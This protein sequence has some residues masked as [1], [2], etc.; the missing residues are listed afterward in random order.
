PIAT[1]P[2]HHGWQEESLSQSSSE[3]QASAASEISL[4]E[5]IRQKTAASQEIES[6]YQLPAEVDA[7]CLTA[8]SGSRLGLACDRTDLTEFPTL[9]EGVLPSAETSRRQW[10][11][12]RA[13]G[14]LM[15]IQDSP[16]SPCLPLLMYSTQGQRLSDET[17]FQQSGRD[18]VPLRGVPDASGASEEH[19]EPLHIQEAVWLTDAEAPSDAPGDCFTVSQHP[20]PFTPAE[21]HEASVGGYLPQQTSCSLA[22]VQSNTEASEKCK[23]GPNEKALILQAGDCSANS[24]SKVMLIQENRT[25]K[26][27]A[28]L[29]EQTCNT[30]VKDERFTCNND[31]PALGFELA[32]KEKELLRHDEFSSSENSSCKTAL[33]KNSGKSE[34]E[35]QMQKVKMAKS[36][37]EG[38]LR[39]LEKAE[40]EKKVPELDFSNLLSDD[41]RKDSC[42]N[43]DAQDA[44]SAK[45]SEIVRESREHG[46]DLNGLGSMKAVAVTNELQGALLDHQQKQG[47]PA[48]RLEKEEFTPV[49]TGTSDCAP[50]QLAV[51]DMGAPSSCSENTLVEPEPGVR[52]ADFTISDFSIERGHKVTDISP[53][54]NIPTDDGSFFRH[55]SH[56]SYQSTPGI[57][58]NK[59]V[60]AE[61]GARVVKS[62]AQGSPLCLNE[63]NCGSSSTSTPTSVDKQHS[64]QCAQKENNKHFESL[65]LKYPHT[66]RIQS[67]PSLNFME[68]VGTWNMSQPGSVCDA[69]ASCVPSVSSPRKK[70]Y[71]ATDIS[72]DKILSIRSSSRNP[73]DSVTPSSGET[74]SLA[75]FHFH[76]KISEC[77]HPLTR[78]QSDNSDAAGKNA[79]P[80][81]AVEPVNSEA[82][83][84]LEAK[85][86]VLGVPESRLG[87][88]LIHRLTAELA[89]GSTDKDADGNSMGQSSDPNAFIPSDSVAQL[90]REDGNSPPDDLKKCD[91]LENERL[92]HNLDTP[93]GRV[94]MDNFGDISP[95]SLN[96]P[97]NSGE[98]SR[99]GLGSAGLSAVISG[100]FFTSAEGDNFI[101][102]GATSLKTPE[103]EEL[104]IEERIPIYLRNLGIDQSPGT[105]L[106][107]FVPRGPIREVEFSPS[108]LRTLKDSTDMLTRTAQQPRGELPAA[109]DI[110][111]TSF[112]SGTSTVSV[113]VPMNSEVGSGTL[114]PRELSPCFSR[115]FGDK[116]TSQCSMSCHQVE[117]TAPLSTQWETKCSGVS[118]VAEPSQHLQ[119]VSPGCRSN[120]QSPVLVVKNE[121]EDMRNNSQRWTASSGAGGKGEREAGKGSQT[122]SAGSERNKGQESD[123]QIRSGA[124]QEILKLLAEAEDIAGSWHDPVF[125]TASSRETGES[126]PGLPEKEDGPIDSEL[127]KD[128]VPQFQKIFSWDETMTQ[129]SRQE[130]RSVIK[131]LDSHKGSLKWEC[132][133]DVSL[134]SRK[135]MTEVTKEFRTEKSVG[136]SEP[137]GCSSVTTDRNQPGFVTVAQ[138]N[139]ESELST[140]R[141]SELGNPPPSEPLGS[142]TNVLEASWSGLLKASG[143]V[144]TA[145]GIRE[146]GSTSAD[147]LAARVKNLLGNPS[148]SPV[149]TT[150]VPGGFQSMLSKASAAGSQAGGMQ[151]SDGSS[152]GDSLA[153]R[154][155]NLLRNPSEP[156]GSIV[157]VPRGFPS[158]LK[159]NVAGSQAGGVQESDGSSSGDSLAARVKNLLRNGAPG[160]PTTQALRS[161]DEEERK[162]RA[163]VKLKLAS[164]SQES[165]SDLNEEDQQR[166]QEIKAELL[167]SARKSGRA[168]GPW[169]CSL[170]AALEHSCNQE[171]D[172]EHFRTPSDRRFHPDSPAQASR[173]K[174]LSEPSLQQA[175]PLGRAE[176][177]DS[178]LLKDTQ[179]KPLSTAEAPACTQP[180]AASHHAD[181]VVG[182]HPPLQKEWDAWA[183]RSA[184]ASGA[185]T[186][187]GPFPAQKKLSFPRCSEEMSKQ[188]TSITF[189]S[190]RRFQSPLISMV[191]DGDG[192]DEIVPLEVGSASTEEQSHGRQHWERSE[193]CPPS[194]PGLAG[195][196]SNE[197]AFPAASGRFRDVSA[198]SNRAGAYQEAAC[199]S[200]Q[201]AEERQT[202][203]AKS[204]DVLSQDVTEPGRHSARLLM[205]DSDTRVSQDSSG[206]HAPRSVNSYQQ[207][208][209][210]PPGHRCESSEGSSPAIQTDLSEGCGKLME[211]EKCPGAVLL[212]QKES[213]EQSGASHHS[214]PDEILSTT[215]G[216]PSSPIKKVLSCVH[217]TLSPKCSNLELPR[218]LSTEK[219]M[220]LGNK[221]EVN[222]QSMP[223]KTPETS[224][225]AVPKLPP[226]DLVLEDQRC[227]SLTVPVP[228]AGPCLVLS[229]VPSTAG[230]EL[231]SEGGE[232]PQAVGSGAC[233]LKNA[234]SCLVPAKT[235]STSDAA[236]QITTESPEKTT[237]SAEIYVSSQDG[238]SAAHQP[239][240]QETHEFPKRTTS[241]HNKIPSFPRQGGQ[242]VLLPYKPSGSTGMYYV[243]YLKPGSNI[244]PLGSE[245]SAESCHSGSNDAHP[246]RF[247]VSVLGLQDGKPPDRTA[248]RHK[249]G[250]CSKR[251]MPRLAWAEEQMLPLEAAPEHTHHLKTV[252]TTH[253]AFTSE[254]FSLHHPVSVRESCSSSSELSGGCAGVGHTG[255]SLGAAIR[256]RERAHRHGRVASA[257]PRRDGE[258][259]FFL[260][261]AE[262]DDSR[263]EDLNAG[264]PLGNETSGKELPQRGGRGAE[265][266]AAGSCPS[267][268]RVTGL[269][270]SVEKDLPLRRRTHPAGG[271]DELWGKFLERQ[272]RHQQHEWR[273]N[274]E[275]SLVERL[276]RLARVLQ[277]PIRYTLMPAKSES[278]VSGKKNKGKE[279]KKVRLPEKNMSESTLEPQERPCIDCDESSFVELRKSRLG[280][281]VTCHLN[282]AVEHRQYLE[283]SS[284]ASLERRLGKDL[285]TTISSTLSESDATQTDMEAT[286]QA[287]VSS[288][289]STIDTARLIRAFGH[290][291][292]RVSPRLS[293]LYC[294]IHQQKSRSEEWDKGSSRAGSVEYPKVPFE[295]HRKRK[296]T[297]KAV[298]VALDSTSTSS[299]SWGPSSAL[300]NKRRARMLNKGVQAGDLEIVNSATKKNTRDVGVTFPTP[301]SLQPIQR[302]REPWHCVG[303]ISGESDGMVTDHRA[304]GSK[305]ISWFVQAED[306]KSESRK[307]NCS[308]SCPGPGPSWFE[309]LTGTKP[310]REPLREKNCQEQQCSSVTQAA[311]PERDAESR[312]LRPLVKL[313]LQEAL[314]VHRP[315]FIS[316]SGER[317]K[318]LKL[319]MEERRMQSVLQSQREELFNPPEKR[320]GYRNASPMLSDRG[321]LIKEKR[322]TIRKSEMFQRSKRIYE[323]LPEVQRKREEEKRKTEYNSYRLKAQLY[324]MKI[325]NRVLG[326]KVP[327]N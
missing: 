192:L 196:C 279:Q 216:S 140:E 199:L 6:W 153:A 118:K 191:L 253:S 234:C 214:F 129:R 274:G 327:W 315:D 84:P 322:R 277:N 93:T 236:T 212:L 278:N 109:V 183:M 210:S 106:T 238:E 194:S 126:S 248:T 152:S 10:P 113:S 257:H 233:G 298:F 300:S 83:Q 256:S 179:L 24:T 4:G 271:L 201:D 137:E 159:A 175:V 67:L 147:S 107:P 98:S 55:F 75:G 259:E 117:V 314:A 182:L 181:G 40:K 187:K 226:A 164:S 225:E 161:A 227:S 254:R 157:D 168:K 29:A 96:L 91:D 23:N 270:D 297:Q 3:T 273:R 82:V 318:H 223:F 58:L 188:I 95:D 228:S 145:G 209:N 149:S 229:S 319:V 139:A 16:F 33:T 282:E 237:L 104:N 26:M 197:I 289:T 14:L 268:S 251:A 134:H 130:E 143:P 263:N 48:G 217:I 13:H 231:P 310:W 261:N 155:K 15:D 265:Q 280:E 108:D 285:C 286:A 32:E 198:G 176:P 114:S 160:T 163:W 166:I 135:E 307:E 255:P 9:E 246:L 68:K 154:V 74:R 37:S 186:E 171:R 144:S 71:S 12:N 303:G 313:T 299:S 112:D 110:T 116:P 65:K 232:R 41:V 89:S 7:S 132:S 45:T 86:N 184:A 312:P 213:A 288:S 281:K 81:E 92:P 52:K 57:F 28:S 230:Q 245:T 122:S 193:A 301:R 101:P 19:S 105:I 103:K 167:L 151:D 292:V 180:Q 128:S 239:S 247:P 115:S 264:T 284:D 267:C 21:L 66:G 203:S 124:V 200:D 17:L 252:K 2:P 219:D 326:R 169:S 224:L 321:Y 308:N 148:V 60:K 35:M 111:E 22:V 18:F 195:S 276:D 306:L 34:G 61:L 185:Q 305:G 250:I 69:L 207:E 243:P 11:G 174:E 249:E 287:E 189:S 99:G 323:Q 133:F 146:S 85:S 173:T 291:R 325:T 235:R 73:K 290:E 102:L 316:R 79:S 62:D 178:C 294:T 272:Q 123:S 205:A 138:S 47:S 56:P 121:L 94:S 39:H 317:V 38:C 127:V 211:E 125:S 54:F 220:R 76:S 283:T 158:M 20:L 170:G 244:F 177:S 190:R 202:L 51:A 293:Q 262:A 295:R 260:L 36:E 53:S 59:N 320:K 46:V 141:P 215:S 87:G 31:V 156:L 302:A 119:T 90:L 100:H 222:S 43:S 275:L 311:A 63:D 221:L 218:D 97:A 296:E 309:P 42:K 8:A 64:L 324:K 72:S 131:P 206:L 172:K 1:T 77:G 304:A 142:V 44:F 266:R 240:L 258:R 78:S 25:N 162:A 27:E 30:C 165:V 136:R 70:A 49:V 241:S 242:P 204:P 50:E 269:H 208:K 88:S 150:P 120:S 5:A 80:S